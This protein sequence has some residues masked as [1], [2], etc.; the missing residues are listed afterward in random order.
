M[1][2]NSWACE[3]SSFFVTLSKAKSLLSLFPK[4]YFAAL[5][6]TG[7][8]CS[9]LSFCCEQ[10]ERNATKERKTAIKTKS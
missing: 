2:A 5:N 1:K 3:G 10:K 7:L 8:F 6:M 4:R 9:F